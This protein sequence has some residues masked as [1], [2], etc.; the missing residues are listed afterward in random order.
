MPSINKDGYLSN[1][2]RKDA[3]AYPNFQLLYS[4][5]FSVVFMLNSTI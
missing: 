4:E 5:N 1:I 2:H 3:F